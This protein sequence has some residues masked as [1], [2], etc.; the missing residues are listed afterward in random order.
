MS[1]GLGGASVDP[2][3]ELTLY[4]YIDITGGDPD[5]T[6]PSGDILEGPGGGPQADGEKISKNHSLTVYVTATDDVAV[7]AV[8]AMFDADGD[9]TVEAYETALAD[10][11]PESGLYE[12]TVE[13]ISGPVGTR[14]LQ[15]VVFDASGNYATDS[16]TIEVTHD[17]AFLADLFEQIG[18]ALQ[19]GVP[20]IPATVSVPF[21]QNGL[22]DV[23]DFTGTFATLADK[24]YGDVLVTG[25][26]VTSPV[27]AADQT[28]L[29]TID[30]AAPLVVTIDAARTA[31]NATI[32][33]LV[34]DIND[35]LT[36][37]GLDTELQAGS[38]TD[39]SGTHLTLEASSD[40]ARSMTVTTLQLRADVAVPA[41]YGQLAGDASL[42]LT[43]TRADDG[44]A[45]T[46]ETRNYTLLVAAVPDPAD[47][48]LP[49]TQDNALPSDLVDDLN[50]ALARAGV[51]GVYAR[52]D[53]GGRI[54]FSAID[55]NIE[56]LTITDVIAGSRAAIG[57]TATSSA[58]ATVTPLG[59]LH[60]QAIAELRYSTLDDFGIVLQDV[61]SNYTDSPLPGGFAVNVT[62]DAPSDTLH[63]NFAL[64]KTYQKTV[65]LNLLDSGIDLGVFGSLDLAAIGDATFAVTAG[66]NF[67]LGI[68]L[69][70]L[71]AGFTITGSTLLSQLNGGA[72]VDV[73]VGM[74]ADNAAPSNGQL[75]SNVT[76]TL[77][78]Q[79]ED[80]SD[81]SSH[82]FT[83]YQAPSAGD[84][85]RPAS[86]DNSDVASLVSDLNTLL[87]QAGLSDTLEAATYTFQDAGGAVTEQRVMLRAIQTAASGLSPIR[88]LRI[89]GAEALGFGTNQDGNFTDL[90]IQV[91][92]NASNTYQIDLD[93][94]Q[95]VQDVIDT[96]QSQTG[97]AVTAAI[98]G[99][100]TG[101]QL[102]ADGL[103][104]VEAGFA[105][106]LFTD[107]GNAADDEGRT[108]LAGAGLGL[109][110]H[111]VYGTV[112][113]AALHGASLT[114]RVFIDENP[115]G[116]A[117]F[118][119]S[120]S[121]TAGLDASAALGCLGLSLA[122]TTPLSFVVTAQAHLADPNHNDSRIYLS[123]IVA[124]PSAVVD[125]SGATLGASATG[126]IVLTAG[127]TELDPPVGDPDVLEQASGQTD[128][129]LTLAVS[130]N[131]A[132]G[133]SFTADTNF[134]DI[135]SQFKNVC[136]TD[137]LSL[138][139]NVADEL[140]GSNVPILNVEIPLV[141]KS[142]GELINFGDGLVDAASRFLA[143]VDVTQVEQ[144]L[145]Q[146]DTAI[147]NLSLPVEDRDRLFRIGD[148]LR[149]LTSTPEQAPGETAVTFQSRLDDFQERLPSKLLS[150]LIQ[151]GKIINA[152]VPNG[153]GGK[154]SLE[155]AF[156]ALADLLPSWNTLANRL[157][158]VIE[159]ALVNLGFD[160][161]D[162]NVHLG[163]VDYD[164]NP[165]TKDQAL[166]VG[167]TIT[168][169]VNDTFAPQLPVTSEFGPISFEIDPSLAVVAG[170]T[171]ALGFGIKL[172][173]SATPFVIVNPPT[174]PD[175]VKTSLNLNA[176]FDGQVSGNI[177]LGSLDLVE[178]SA[179]L[180][181]AN[182]VHETKTVSGG[183]V[184]LAGAP[185][186]SDER[187]V[188]V[189]TGG[190]LVPTEDFTI[191][192]ITL[193][194]TSLPNGTVVSVEYQ[195]A[196]TPGADPDP[197]GDAADRAQLDVNFVPSSPI[198]GN[199]IGAV[200]FGSWFS[201]T[202]VTATGM[203]TGAVDVSFLGNTVEKGVTLA[204]RLNNLADPRLEVDAEALGGLFT[205]LDFDLNTII[206]GIERVLELL[207]DGLTSQVV[208]QIPVIGD[209]FNTAGT[210]IGKMEG[211][212]EDFRVALASYGG[213]TSTVQGLVQSFIFSKLGPAGVNILGDLN[214]PAGIDLGDVQVE[215]DTEH[216]QIFF[217][218]AGHDEVALDFDIGLHGLPITAD[219][220]GGLEFG[221]DYQVDFGIGVDRE[222]GVY[223]VA[224][225]VNPELT[226][227][228]DAGL[229]V[230]SS[231][232]QYVPTS[233]T[234]DLFGLQLSATD[235]VN[236]STGVPG[237]HVGGTVE[238]DLIPVSGNRLPLG[239]LAS[240]S[241]VD[242]FSVDL[243]ATA[244]VDLILEAG[245]GSNLPSLQTELVLGCS[246]GASLVGGAL[247][248]SASCSSIQL[249]NTGINLG[250]FLSKHVGSLINRLKEYL[251][252]IEPVIQL[253]KAEVPGLSQ[254]SQAAGN[255][256]L[257]MLDL[258][259]MDEPDIAK[260][261][262]KFVDALDTI[263]QIS[264]SLET[265][266]NDASITSS[267][268]QTHDA[269][270][271]VG[272]LKSLLQ[273][274]EELGINL[275]FLEIGNIVRML[276]GQP[277]DVISY[278]LPRFELPF[279]FAQKFPV[280]TPPPISVEVGLNAQVFADLSVGYDS[281]GLDTGNFFDGFYFGDRA[282]VFTGADIDEFGVGVG[283][284]LAALLDL[285]VASAGVKGE[286][287]ADIFANWRD[288]DN[289]GKMH[290]DEL[291]QIV[292]T[293]G[294][295]CV[296]DLR[297]EL[298]ALVSIV[299]SV[300]GAD[301]S[302]T[303]IDALL[304]SFHNTCPTFQLGHVAGAGEALPD[305][306][307]TADGTLVLHAGA[308][309]GKRGP[310]SS[311]D[312]AE[313]FTVTQVAPGVYD[314]EGLALKSRYAGVSSIFF[315]GGAGDDAL[316]LTNVSVPVT[317][318]GGDGKDTLQGGS[319]GDHLD[320]GAGN[321]E[322][323]GYAG[324]D[325][326][327][328]GG[329]NDT[330]DGAAGNDTIS[331]GAGDDTIDGG[332]DNDT[333]DGGSG[334]DVIHGRAG[335][336]TIG[337]GS[338]NDKIF[339]GADNDTLDGGPGADLILGE[340]GVDTIH[341]GSGGDLISGG[342][343][344]DFLYGDSGNDLIVGG[345]LDANADLVTL[346]S[347]A[348]GI[349]VNTLDKD[350][351]SAPDQ[352]DELWG[353][354]DNDLLIGDEGAD[355]LYGGWGNDVILA[356]LLLDRSTT[357][358]EYI[359]GGPDND[360]VCGGS[361]KDEIYGGTHS[362]AA[363]ASVLGES[364]GATFGGAQVTSCDALPTIELA[365]AGDVSGQVF[366][367]ADA[368]GT[369]DSS[370]NGLSG[371]TVNLFDSSGDLVDSRLTASD[372]TYAFSGVD[373][374][375]Y[376]VAEVLAPGY[377]QSSGRRDA[378]RPGLRQ[379]LPGRDDPG[380][381]VPRLERERPAGSRRVRL[382]W[383]ADSVAGRERRTG[384]QHH[385]GRLR[386]EPQRFHRPGHRTWT[387]LLQRGR[388]EQL[389][390]DR[391]A[392]QW[393]EPERSGPERRGDLHVHHRRRLLADP[394]G[395]P[396]VGADGHDHRC[397]RDAGHHARHAGAVATVLAQPLR[398]AHR[399]GRRRGRRWCELH[400]HHLRRRRR[401][402]DRWLGLRAVQRCVRAARCVVRFE[403]RGSQWGLD[404]GRTG[405][406]RGR[407]RS[408]EQLVGDDLHQR[409]R[410]CRVPGRQSEPVRTG[411]PDRLRTERGHRR[412]RHTQ[413]RQLPGRQR[414]WR[415]VRG[416]GWRRQTQAER[417]RPAGCHD[418]RRPE[419]QR[420]TGSARTQCRDRARRSEYPA[421]ERGRPLCARA[422]AAGQ[423]RDSRSRAAAGCADIPVH[424]ARIRA[425]GGL[426][427]AGQLRRY[428]LRTGFRQRATR[429]NTWH[430]MAGRQR[431]RR[432]RRGGTR[433]GQRHGVCG[434]EQQR[435]AGCERTFRDHDVRR[436]GH[437][438]RR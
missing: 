274:I 223:L 29:I 155:T 216:F 33:A 282:N 168:H 323:Y 131:T 76:F 148:L 82:T 366:L 224:D 414:A 121:V 375:N 46:S 418:L 280:W 116:P 349:N 88:A 96:I 107:N 291:V 258:A 364:G 378:D 171:L 178:A 16:V 179:S 233:L 25:Q 198:V 47:A 303:F 357:Y 65:E 268:G 81:D 251:E 38:T 341:G 290:L 17:Y 56:Q 191:S 283:V 345:R 260:I 351:D 316:Y 132:T 361:G 267:G 289:D 270:G 113:G 373:Y 399:P 60:G 109:L 4:D 156:A 278:K 41:P 207:K 204:V 176:G 277:F 306:S 14:T 400:E 95:N 127:S 259:L 271:V 31:G 101:L 326:M 241:F 244:Q 317:A 61:L 262:R 182:A 333:I 27:L 50:A 187:F 356:H 30:G 304:F 9:G 83:L 90:T 302:Y 407:R 385:D 8:L 139:S 161:G 238:L 63:F 294:I 382:E 227:T 64:N 77:N 237:T 74:T 142:L 93:G 309:A 135:V 370:E 200:P 144:T 5:Y 319:V 383:L 80:S 434:R 129:L 85:S 312:V 246:A 15:A 57:F 71:G 190:S 52:L 379:L 126:T 254:L 222:Q 211:F 315:D 6:S 395:C 53:G 119:F 285:V 330:I 347:T 401:L 183:S 354:L 166:V 122:T 175:L 369:L 193:T 59:F 403:R 402:A 321:D 320:G 405:Q 318:Y 353:G 194:F 422:A 128:P 253:L 124:D 84:P 292:E 217:R 130:G 181:L 147:S 386:L 195:T 54:V 305:G 134:Q 310:G 229:A 45:L 210:F 239:D 374:G 334:N 250:D 48:E 358:T 423:L 112:Q 314:V 149:G 300:F 219:G 73:A 205:N 35:V 342:S 185:L 372:G 340:A 79:R 344:G 281:H 437:Q 153:T 39:G 154:S 94:A 433:P 230:E 1:R 51:D 43:V 247:D 199:A 390:G 158:T 75:G 365:A 160:V 19:A 336:D 152:D 249:K 26:A 162:I 18:Q 86:N 232:G 103:I 299:W 234:I 325:T 301:G 242:L 298:R 218:L 209:G 44:Q 255:G 215:L 92:G 350:V 287:R 70:E 7:G 151:L 425:A 225:A 203:V 389:L 394:F 159:D 102:S 368:D 240:A 62:Y 435:P 328:G 331:G 257:T 393:L 170:G 188:V 392:A 265:M 67:G 167:L 20:E 252:P 201:N 412:R 245:L 360:F 324:A 164:G 355:K 432:P 288:Q 427:R 284:S 143:T 272:T 106:T 297:G 58:T 431:Q 78:V 13:N 381:E 411:P 213:D 273:K 28:L 137:I 69:G 189:T 295:G 66:L 263:L 180:I 279:S 125:M 68:Y 169:T 202:N 37:Q 338:G 276:L 228:I 11:N 136:L 21:L 72:G 359:E 419:Q 22:S 165:A 376:S 150:G 32:A 426:H 231:G 266:D 49:Y 212:V 24:L 55:V 34:A 327:D 363:L 133:F 174:N 398:H 186:N 2:G 391:S 396:G 173:S 163:F 40:S 388:A 264:H 409:R 404:T 436:P 123:E 248:V 346:I 335:T 380:C 377:V 313:A 36:E 206:Y 429:R 430:Q 339:G 104:T 120:A 362:A 141:N 91:V 172:D 196:V 343:A 23:I 243:A 397:E 424:A 261:A 146:L 367:D 197:L 420:P 332:A 100:H 307:T 256:P 10:F 384:G 117:N 140:K 42:Q 214:A 408:A 387:V 371:W 145:Q 97:S 138:L 337:G 296:F 311:S 220:Q 157:E 413:L 428:D 111:Q 99:D 115:S 348:L 177:S 416:P 275:H 226:F 308:F 110:A 221:W 352:A 105:V 87:T 236:Q 208:T 184:T 192:G 98:D 89:S 329:G 114:D 410:Q 417:T 235:N 293:D 3:D 415:Q 406:E 12:A 421:G 286:I 108:S 438:E 269:D 118:T 322:L